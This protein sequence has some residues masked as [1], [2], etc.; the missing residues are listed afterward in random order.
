MTIDVLLAADLGEAAVLDGHRA[1]GRVG[2]VKRGEQAPMQ[3][4][5]RAVDVGHEGFSGV[6]RPAG[7]LP[8]T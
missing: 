3:D 7:R 2:S 5:V 1:G 6:V 4:Q 8:N